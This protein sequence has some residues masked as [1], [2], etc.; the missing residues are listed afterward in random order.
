MAKSK[1]SVLPLLN[2]TGAPDQL[3]LETLSS[4][5]FWDP[6]LSYSPP[7]SIA[8]LQLVSS[9]LLDV[10]GCSAPGPCP[11]TSLS[12]LIPYGRAYSLMDLDTS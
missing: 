12:M 11:Q 10:K 2:P 9:H 3:L 7:T 1:V 5:D 6:T 4:F 8:P